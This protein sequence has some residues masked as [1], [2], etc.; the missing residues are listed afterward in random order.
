MGVEPHSLD[1]IIID[2]G[3][4]QFQW[5]DR[6]RGFCHTR[7]G[8]LDLRIDFDVRPEAP[9]ASRVLASTPEQALFFIL[10]N[11]SSMVREAKFVT[12]AIIEGRYMFH[13]FQTTQE[14]Y[15]VLCTAARK[16]LAAEG[17]ADHIGGLRESDLALR[18]MLETVTALRMFV[19]DEINELDFA[20]RAVA[21]GFLKKDTGVLLSIL[22]T[23]PEERVASTTFED[24]SD[25]DSKT[26]WHPVLE[27]ETDSDTNSVWS[28]PL[29]KAEK[30]LHPRFPSAKLFAASNSLK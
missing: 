1:G 3:C 20:F 11:Y 30:V 24:K 4:S 9:T 17:G 28:M 21:E 8:H 2:T 22:H 25:V 10:R 15:D 5:Q 27:N 19:N 6:R 18:M 7:K 13:Q 29:S 12:N 16:M 26:D 14:L 23:K